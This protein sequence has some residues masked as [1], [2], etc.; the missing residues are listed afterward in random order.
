MS[1]MFKRSE[2]KYDRAFINKAM[3][4]NSWYCW[5]SRKGI[6][7]TAGLNELLQYTEQNIQIKYL[8][9]V[10]N[11]EPITIQSKDGIPKRFKPLNSYKDFD[12]T[13]YNSHCIFA[14]WN[15]K[16][17]NDKQLYELVESLP[18]KSQIMI[19]EGD[20]KYE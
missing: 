5:Y 1:V 18:T 9:I 19:I 4:T 16:N 6:I 20:N 13:N 3:K 14:V 7:S 12:N 17:Y 2:T 8:I 10:N 15:S 11:I